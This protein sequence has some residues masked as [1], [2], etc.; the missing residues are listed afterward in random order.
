MLHMGRPLGMVDCH[1]H[2]VAPQDHVPMW[3]GRSY[4]PAP[5]SLRDWAETLEPLGVTHGVVVQ[6]S[7]YG[8]D[9]RVLLAAL[10]QGEGRLV[11]VAAVAA[12]LPEA[13]LDRLVAAGVRGVRMAHFE[14]GDPRAMGG[15]V[16]LRDNF[17]AL[18]DRLAERGLHLQLFTDSRLLPAIADRLCRARVP[19]VIDHLGRAPASLGAVHEG[20][21]T[22]IRLMHEAPVWTKLSGV[23]NISD[24]APGYADARAVHEALV[25]AAPEHLVWGSDWPHTRPAGPRPST[26]AL[27]RLFEAWTPPD[28]RERIGSRNAAVLY[29]FG[30]HAPGA[31]RGRCVP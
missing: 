20:I 2:V 30:R 17:D 4:T 18:E 13:E 12:D 10:A 14:A 1:F 21:R 23:A 25:E 22:L 31:A 19:V 6:P 16:A 11:G 15:F 24:A 27:V 29:R 26:A 7:V 8:T 28:L 5:A 3:P 9:N